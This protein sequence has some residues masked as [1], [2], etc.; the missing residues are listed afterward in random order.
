MRKEIKLFCF[1]AKCKHLQVAGRKIRA[2]MTCVWENTCVGGYAAHVPHTTTQLQRKTQKTLCQHRNK[3][4]NKLSA[5]LSTICSLNVFQKTF[6]PL[7]SFFRWNKVSVLRGRPDF[8]PSGGR[9]IF[10]SKVGTQAFMNPGERVVYQVEEK[11][12]LD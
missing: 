8:C 3:T 2:L 10:P 12:R 4:L 6:T 5:P 9:R 11:T 1:A 7:S